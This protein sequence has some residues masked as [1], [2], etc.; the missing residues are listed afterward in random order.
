MWQL[1]YHLTNIGF[2]LLVQRRVFARILQH[3]LKLTQP[4]LAGAK[5]RGIE[6]WLCRND[7][8]LD[9]SYFVSESQ[10]CASRVSKKVFSRSDQG[11]VN[12]GLAGQFNAA[13][14]EPAV[15]V[16]CYGAFDRGSH[17]V[18]CLRHSRTSVNRNSQSG[19]TH[20]FTGNWMCLSKF[21]ILD[22]NEVCALGASLLDVAPL[23]IAG[24]DHVRS[25]VENRCLMHVTERPVI[26]SLVDEVIERAGSIV[27]VASRT[28][29]PRMKHA[30]V[31]HARN[32]IRVSWHQ[33]VGDISL[34]EA[35]T[36][37]CDAEFFKL[38]RL[39]LPR[40]KCLH[41][42]G[43]NETTGDLALC[44]MVAVEQEDV[45]TGCCESAHLSNKEKPS[46]VITPVPIIEI[47]RDDNE[48]DLFLKNL[49]EKVLK[50]LASRGPDTVSR[51][52]FVP[53]E[54]LQGAVEMDVCR[55]DK[56]E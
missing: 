47:T 19:P 11:M 42:L 2:D 45:N 16:V 40:G 24:E 44:I 9:P 17:T 36:V 55:V 28:A 14:E 43:E 38:E 1:T 51:A 35:L 46:L 39:G 10:R 31:E 37:E 21:A 25:L 26:V 30:E 54:T 5:G 53:G 34:P 52:A 29:Q 41:V 18:R 27:C 23:E 22:C 3:A 33:V 56:P 4:V 32:G 15:C 8:S 7:D 12:V 13:C 20:D 48:G 49:I 50:R 6:Q